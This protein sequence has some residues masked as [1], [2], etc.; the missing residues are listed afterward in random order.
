VYVKGANIPEIQCVSDLAPTLSLARYIQ[1][2]GRAGRPAKGKTKFI[3]LDHAGNSLRHGFWSQQREYSLGEKDDK[4]PS[5]YIASTKMCPSCFYVM[6]STATHCELCD[7]IFASS[8]N[9]PDHVDGELEEVIVEDI[10]IVVKKGK[11]HYNSHYLGEGNF[12]TDASKKYWTGTHTVRREKSSYS[13]Y[14]KRTTSDNFKDAVLWLLEVE[15]GSKPRR[16]LIEK[17][18]E[19]TRKGHSPQWA[20]LQYKNKYKHYPKM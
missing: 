16:F 18:L 9:I 2:I 7:F 6:L 13:V 10:K 20:F 5:E 1:K 17:I 15:T 8:V 19:G 14:G 11:V 3:Q 4:K 12:D